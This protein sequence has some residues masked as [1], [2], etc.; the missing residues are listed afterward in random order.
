[1]KIFGHDN[2]KTIPE[3]YCNICDLE[4]QEIDRLPTTDLE[5]ARVQHH[6]KKAIEG[7]RSSV[8]TLKDKIKNR[9]FIDEKNW[10][11]TILQK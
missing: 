8:K 7:L 5:V 1:M 9:T 10:L 3:I 11:I 2:T 4:E 6:L